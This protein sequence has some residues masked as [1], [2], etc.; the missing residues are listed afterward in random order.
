V[1]HA[2]QFES[3]VVPNVNVAD[4]NGKHSGAL[5]EHPDQVQPEVTDTHP[6]DAQA[7]QERR[8]PQRNRRQTGE[9]WNPTANRDSDQEPTSEDGTALLT[10]DGD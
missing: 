7:E 3:A 4:I 8:Y 2:S 6:V 10:S 5:P 9:W 1:S